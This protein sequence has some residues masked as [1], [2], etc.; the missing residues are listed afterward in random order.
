MRELAKETIS[1][2][3]EKQ[4]TALREILDTEL[5]AWGPRNAQARDNG[6]FVDGDHWGDSENR[7]RKRTVPTKKTHKERPTIN[8]T[9]RLVKS[10]TAILMDTLARPYFQWMTIDDSQTNEMG[11]AFFSDYWWNLKTTDA[12]FEIEKCLY[13]A[14]QHNQAYLKFNFRAPDGIWFPYGGVTVEFCSV[15]QVFPD[16]SE[17]RWH[18][19]RHVIYCAYK[20]LK[21]VEERYGVIAVEEPKNSPSITSSTIASRDTMGRLVSSAYSAGYV[22]SRDGDQTEKGVW[23]VE[24][25]LRDN[26]VEEKDEP[27][28]EDVLKVDEIGAP[29][30][31]YDEKW[32]A[33]RQE[34]ERKQKYE[35]NESGQQIAV[36][37]KVS[38]K[39]YPLGKVITIINDR[40]VEEIPNPHPFGFFP[41]VDLVDTV[42]IDKDRAGGTCTVDDTKGPNLTIDKIFGRQLEKL[43]QELMP[44]VSLPYGTEVDFKKIASPE[45]GRVYLTPPFAQS[46]T[47]WRNTK[48]MSLAPMQIVKWLENIFEALGGVPGEVGGQESY[49][50]QSGASIERLQK[51]AMVTLRLMQRHLNRMIRDIGIVA[52][53]MVF[54]A[55]DNLVFRVL[56][57]NIEQLVIDSMP[58]S[59]QKIDPIT[60]QPAIDPATGQPAMEDKTIAINVWKQYTYNRDKFKDLTNGEWLRADTIVKAVDPSIITKEHQ[61]ELQYRFLKDGYI[62]FPQFLRAGYPLANYA[63]IVEDYVKKEV[64]AKVM[65]SQALL[66]QLKTPVD[67]GVQNAQNIRTQGNIEALRMMDNA[68]SPAPAGEQK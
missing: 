38:Y 35:T 4:I 22:A 11:N 46:Q 62:T 18:D 31:N 54:M 53:P 65:Q 45:G 27:E 15:F 59:E 42:N 34:T 58:K 25:W 60:G 40:I 21:W 12:E 30:M 19:K 5:I 7:A 17:D 66:A 63:E 29:V 9:R 64:Q 39:K 51:G 48:D 47:N 23:I 26:E 10:A 8:L 41:F 55:Y 68:Q 67:A 6:K 36:T 56:N 33:V 50:G 49:A 20:S 3:E 24:Y 13:A 1:E 32:R 37:K 16:S 14:F 2:K 44:D 61:L 57:T 28:Y 43:G 52:G